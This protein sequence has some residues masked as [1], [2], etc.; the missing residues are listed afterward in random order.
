M[1]TLLFAGTAEGHRLYDALRHNGQSVTA[2]VATEYGKKLLDDTVL[3][4]R[5]NAAQMV[6]LLQQGGY[7]QI[8]DATHPFATEVTKNIRQAAAQT[9]V[10]Y[11]R[12]LRQSSPRQGCTECQ[13]MEEAIRCINSREGNLLST[14]GSKSL[15][16]LTAI[17]GYQ[18]RVIPR[19]LPIAENV[20]A[21]TALGYRNLV[22]MQGPFSQELNRAMLRQ[23]ACTMLLTKDTG[24]TG[25]F[26]EKVA[27]AQEV[28]AQVIVVGRPQPEAGLTYAQVLKGYGIVTKEDE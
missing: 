17:Q 4:G 19:I 8:I 23:F 26:R 12:L 21:A 1:K 18:Q 13:D 6:A 20:A 22:C 24:E 9:G 16:Q 15:A 28:G 10:E 7:D 14:V 27:A 2:C 25:G 5:L 11:V 3:A